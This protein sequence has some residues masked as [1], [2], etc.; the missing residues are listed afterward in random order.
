MSFKKFINALRF[1]YACE[2]LPREDVS[3]TEICGKCGFGSL[4]NFNRVFKALSGMTPNEYRYKKAK[5]DGD[6]YA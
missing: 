5:S 6:I 4:R 1:E 2:L 3:I